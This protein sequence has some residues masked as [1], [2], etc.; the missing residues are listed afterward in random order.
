VDERLRLGTSEL[1][2]NGAGLKKRAFFRV[3]VSSL[4]LTEKRTS[5][6]DVLAL[7]GP[8]RISITLLRKLSAQELVDARV[9]PCLAG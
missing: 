6:E 3:Y 8:K 1:V 2:L 9:A 7:G 4:C 5:A